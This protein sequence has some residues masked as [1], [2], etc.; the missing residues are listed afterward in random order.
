MTGAAVDSTRQLWVP[1]YGAPWSET[2]LGWAE[3]ASAMSGAED[4][5][6][7]DPRPDAAL[8]L[9]G[10]LGQLG[11]LAAARLEHPNIV[12]VFEAGEADGLPYLAMELVEGETLAAALA[13]ETMSR[14]VQAAPALETVVRTPEG[15]ALLDKLKVKQAVVNV[16]RNAIEAMTEAPIPR[17]GHVLSV[18]VRPAGAGGAPEAWLAFGVSDTGPGIRADVLERMFNPFFTTRASGPGPGDRPPDRGRPRGTHRRAEPG[19]GRG[20]GGDPR[21]PAAAPCGGAGRCRIPG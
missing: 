13:R 1:S 19:P 6:L 3:T 4:H 9:V 20:W 7:I 10:A 16:V 17:A 14:I 12:R 18:G 21:D 8:D 2:A 15:A 5:V 11:E